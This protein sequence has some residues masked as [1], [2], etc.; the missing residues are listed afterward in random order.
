ML[1]RTS[2]TKTERFL[3]GAEAPKNKINQPQSRYRKT[4][5]NGL[6]RCSEIILNKTIVVRKMNFKSVFFCLVNCSVNIYKINMEKKEQL[7]KKTRL[8][9]ILRPL[10]SNYLSVNPVGWGTTP[11]MAVVMA[12]FLVFLVIILQIYNSSIILENVDVDWMDL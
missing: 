8:G 4:H 12:L 1:L 7:G 11:L 9:N 5:T 10:N 2:Q 6:L 3:V